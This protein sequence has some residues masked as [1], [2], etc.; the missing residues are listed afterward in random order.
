MYYCLM[1]KNKVLIVEF[2]PCHLHS[3]KLLSS[4]A[5]SRSLGN[6]LQLWNFEE[7]HDQNRAVRCW[8]GVTPFFL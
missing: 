8:P 3:R 4:S 5:F 2:R 7:H 1:R 6:M